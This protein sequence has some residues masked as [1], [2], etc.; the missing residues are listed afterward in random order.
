MAFTRF[1]GG[2]GQTHEGVAATLPLRP[3]TPMTLPNPP[4]TTTTLP[5]LVVVVLMLRRRGGAR[6]SFPQSWTGGGRAW[7][8]HRE[9]GRS[10]WHGRA[11]ASPVRKRHATQPRREVRH[12]LLSLKIETHKT[13]FKKQIHCQDARYCNLEKSKMAG[14]KGERLKRKGERREGVQAHV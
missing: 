10:L 1:Q 2:R 11:G 4:T 7:A 5:P 13:N 14:R 12:G 8:R 6:R 3:H 9:R